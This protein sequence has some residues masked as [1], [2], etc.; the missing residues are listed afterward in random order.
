MELGNQIRNNRNRLNLS[1]EDLAQKIYVS[2]QTISNW[3]N[4]KNYPDIHSLLLMSN[5]FDIS[6]DQLIKGDLT[7][8]REKV[9]E[10][11]IKVFQFYGNIYTVLLFTSILVAVPLI[12]FLK[13]IGIV[14]LAVLYA[15]TLFY[16]FRVEKYKKKFDIQ[17]Y[18]EIV[19][20]CD[21]EK[22]DEIQ[23]EQE[24][25]KRIYQKI[26]LAIGAGMITIIVSAI[27][28]VIIKAL[29]G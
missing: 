25:G 20:F 21:G 10:D 5:L 3:E 22:L 16:A 9:K 4:E 11:D 8:M 17:T 27:I 2:R 24:S 29:F 15:I 18:R 13:I 14:I 12:Y 19:A 26:L 28:L 7:M 1:Q 23:K 6:L